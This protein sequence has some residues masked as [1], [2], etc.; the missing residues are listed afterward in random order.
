MADENENINQAGSNKGLPPS[1][2]RHLRKVMPENEMNEFRKHLPESF[3]SD[4]SEGLE[5]ITDSK[6]LETVLQKLNKQLSIQLKYKKP[7]RKFR[8]RV[9]P[10]WSYWAIIIILLTCILAFIVIRVLL[11]H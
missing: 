9:D 8:S 3:I 11:R 10:G 1:L 2:E 5:N 4:A 6:Q 7:Q